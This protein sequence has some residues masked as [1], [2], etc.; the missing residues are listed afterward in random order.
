M[1][2]EGSHTCICLFVGPSVGNSV[3]LR[4]AVESRVG[5]Y[6]GHRVLLIS[7]SGCA[8]VGH[9]VGACEGAVGLRVGAGVGTIVGPTIQCQ[10][11]TAQSM[12]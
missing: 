1:K 2:H 12:V 4:V 6:V 9:P 10:V 3:G 8:N 7:N 5:K 11:S